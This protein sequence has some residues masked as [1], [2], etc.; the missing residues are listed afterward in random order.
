MYYQ[1]NNLY[2]NCCFLLYKM[3]LFSRSLSHSAII[4]CVSVITASFLSFHRCTLALEGVIICG[5]RHVLIYSPQHDAVVSS[6]ECLIRWRPA[7]PSA[8]LCRARLQRLT[9]RQLVTDGRSSFS[10]T[11]SYMDSG[12]TTHDLYRADRHHAY[13]LLAMIANTKGV[14]CDIDEEQWSQKG[15]LSRFLWCLF[16]WATPMPKTMLGVRWPMQVSAH[17]H[18]T[19]LTACVLG[20]HEAAFVLDMQGSCPKPSTGPN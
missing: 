10:A 8:L 12:S 2:G 17:G 16:I 6:E 9:E 15:G 3:L 4:S 20:G 7:P 18:L 11:L 19:G 1:S 5:R 14:C 13:D